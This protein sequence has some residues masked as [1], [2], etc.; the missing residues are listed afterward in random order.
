[1]QAHV[2]QSV[3][4][5]SLDYVIGQ[6]LVPDRPGHVRLFGEIPEMPTGR[7]VVQEGG[8]TMFDPT[9]CFGGSGR[10]PDEGLGVT[11]A[12]GRQEV[13][14]GAEEGRRENRGQAA[15]PHDLRP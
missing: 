6:L 5:K 10:E 8:E 13:C 1:M 4:T 7:V 3:L 14:A 11:D 15:T 9:L 12:L 2:F